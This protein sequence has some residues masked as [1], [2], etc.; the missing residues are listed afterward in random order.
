MPPVMV[1]RLTGVVCSQQKKTTGLWRTFKIDLECFT[2]IGMDVFYLV[3][4]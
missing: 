3:T 4:P 2:R 1:G